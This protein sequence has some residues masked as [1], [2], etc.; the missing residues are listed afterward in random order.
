M[1]RAQQ[2]LRSSPNSFILAKKKEPMQRMS[3]LLVEDF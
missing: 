3:A 1:L 2:I